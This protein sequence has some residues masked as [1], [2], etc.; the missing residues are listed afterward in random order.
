MIMFCVAG[1]VLALA[2]SA[3]AQS[4]SLESAPPVVVKTV[5]VAG[6]ADVDAALTE[7]K[8]TYSKAMLAGIEFR[9]DINT[10]ERQ[11]AE[12]LLVGGI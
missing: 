12:K 5:P 1:A 10:M 4:V 6:A 2:A 3:A 9:M 7:I 11:A 8:V